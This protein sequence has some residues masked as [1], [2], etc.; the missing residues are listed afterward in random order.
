LQ[1]SQRRF[2]EGYFTTTTNIIQ[3]CT[4]LTHHNMI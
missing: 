2:E 3:C 4:K 1:K